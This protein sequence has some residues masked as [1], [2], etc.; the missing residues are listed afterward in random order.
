MRNY[1]IVDRRGYDLPDLI[2][3]FA[4]EDEAQ[5]YADEYHPDDEDG[6]VWILQAVEP[7]A[8]EEE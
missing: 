4:S 1:Y 8:K 5:E 7:L 6:G 3:P 2:G